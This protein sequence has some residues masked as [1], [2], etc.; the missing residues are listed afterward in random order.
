SLEPLRDQIGKHYDCKKNYGGD[1]NL[2]LRYV[3][4]DAS[5]TCNARD[6][7]DSYSEKT[8]AMN[9]GFPSDKLAYH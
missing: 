7:I 3:I 6:P 9:Y 8:Y 2:Y 1:Y 5:F 4:R